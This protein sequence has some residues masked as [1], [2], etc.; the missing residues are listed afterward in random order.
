MY[1]GCCEYRGECFS[2]TFCS[3]LQVRG[4]SPAPGQTVTR[5][6][7]ARTSWRVTLAPT[8]EK[9]ASCA[10]CAISASCAATIWSSMPAATPTS[11]RL[12]WG[13]KAALEVRVGPPAPLWVSRRR[14]EPGPGTWGLLWSYRVVLTCAP[15]KPQFH[16]FTITHPT[17][18]GRRAE[19]SAHPPIAPQKEE[20]LSHLTSFSPH[21]LILSKL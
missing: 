1:W 17:G 9:S 12:C 5:S 6:L 8:P 16:S 15:A 11:S 20:I 7:P 18:P 10:H 19:E 21:N 13:V 14:L 4:P 3:L 2:P